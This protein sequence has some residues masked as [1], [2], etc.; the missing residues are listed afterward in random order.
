MEAISSKS[1]K[2]PKYPSLPPSSLYLL[3]LLSKFPILLFF[4]PFYGIGQSK[5]GVVFIGEFNFIGSGLQW[6]SP[7]EVPPLFGIL[8]IHLDLF[9]PIP[10]GDRKKLLSP[11]SGG[12]SARLL[13][14]SRLPLL[15]SLLPHLP[16]ESLVKINVVLSRFLDVHIPHGPVFP[17]AGFF[18]I[19]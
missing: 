16:W 15:D 18:Q 17:L 3:P 13:R 10:G 1:R 4:H 6:K 14:I 19:G 7:N 5:A 11:G 2:Q 12:R 8:K 9:C